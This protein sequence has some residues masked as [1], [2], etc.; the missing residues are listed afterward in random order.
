MNVLL[1]EDEPLAAKR[2]ETLVK[3]I[4]PEAKIVAKPE[5]VR[6]AVRWLK[7]EPEP[8]LI[9]MDVQL[10]DGLSFEI[11]QQIEVSAPV[12]F[13]T[14]YDEYA[15]RAFKVNSIDYLL[16][17][18]EQEELQA[19][20]AKF[21]SR[22][23]QPSSDQFVRMLEAF[24]VRPVSYKSRF[25]LKQGSR[26]EVVE[27][28][29]IQYLFAEDKVVLL[30]TSGGK[31]FIADDTLDELEKQLDP[32][33]YFRLNR[34]YISSLSAIERMEPYFNGRIRVWLRQRPADEEILVSR[35]RAE[36]FRNWLN[37]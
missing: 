5:S 12:I 27:T 22:G 37:S 21:R 13:T 8:D 30:Y 23:H 16:K 15:L 18:I 11:F 31:K 26:L 17:P 4:A 34:K 6:A 32:R 19:A 33:H 1:V 36:S 2:L 20:F 24:G 35:E 9:L 29:D 7:S 14:A 10:A 25:L 28:A 3:E